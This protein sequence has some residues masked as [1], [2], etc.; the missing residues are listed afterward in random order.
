MKVVVIGSSNI[1]M[2]AQVNHLPA[3]GETVGDVFCGAFSVC[4]SEGHSLA[5]SVK[6]ANAA[7][8]IAVTRIGA[9]SAIPYKR[10]VVL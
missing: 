2:V 4:L 9:Q 5:K 10:E 6:F 7:A 8:A 3:P 1:D